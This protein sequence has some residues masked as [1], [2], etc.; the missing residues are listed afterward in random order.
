MLIWIIIYE[1]QP[2]TSG[3]FLTT[4]FQSDHREILTLGKGR[5]QTKIY[6]EKLHLCNFSHF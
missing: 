2:R 6:F 5:E 4:A 3:I 1:L